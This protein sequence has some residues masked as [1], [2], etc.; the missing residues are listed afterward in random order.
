M[1]IAVGWTLIVRSS[2]IVI[3]RSCVS[4]VSARPASAGGSARTLRPLRGLYWPGFQAGSRTSTADSMVPVAPLGLM[5]PTDRTVCHFS[6]VLRLEIVLSPKRK[7]ANPLLPVSPSISTVT[8]RPRYVPWTRIERS[9]R[10]STAKPNRS[11][12][13]VH[14]CVSVG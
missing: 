14:A 10:S 3:R 12:S 9:P 4:A 6:R 1:M 5:Q 7:R 11:P 13:I 2:A 8:M